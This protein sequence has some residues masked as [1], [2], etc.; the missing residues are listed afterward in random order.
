MQTSLRTTNLI[1]THKSKNAFST[2]Y[3]GS[4]I[5]HVRSQHWQISG[6]FTWKSSGKEVTFCIKPPEQLCL[7]QIRKHLLQ[8]TNRTMPSQGTNTTSPANEAVIVETLMNVAGCWLSTPGRCQGSASCSRV[9]WNPPLRAP[10]LRRARRRSENLLSC[11]TSKNAAFCSPR[12]RIWR[13]F[14]PLLEPEGRFHA[15]ARWR[16]T[17]LLA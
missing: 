7:Q 11:T 6:S 14:V 1:Q 5:L 13:N 4:G 17:L 8:E 3:S 16:C 10:H 15:V 12:S 9:Q 2:K